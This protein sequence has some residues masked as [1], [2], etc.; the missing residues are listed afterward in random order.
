MIDLTNAKRHVKDNLSGQGKHAFITRD[1][2]LLREVCSRYGRDP[3]TTCI[4]VFYVNPL[5]E[6]QTLDDALWGDNKRKES[7]LRLNSKLIESTQIQNLLWK[8]GKSPRVFAVFEAKYEGERI[9]CQLTEF[10]DGEAT[11]NINDCYA[12]YANT[13]I[14]GKTYGFKAWKN[15]INCR[16]MIGGKFVDPQPFAFEDK[17]Y[18][19]YV[20]DVYSDKGKYGKVYYQDEPEIGLTGGPRKSLDRIKYMALG[21]INFKDKV[22]WDVGCATGYFC[23]YAAQRGAKRVIGL[24]MKQPLEAAF[25]VGNYLKCFNIDYVECNLNRGIPVDKIPKADIAFFLSL[26]LHVG[27]PEKLFEVDTVIFEDNGKESRA[28]DKLGEPW[29]RHYKNIEFVGRGE[30]HGMKSCYAIRK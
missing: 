28:L 30:D 26:N 15:I 13:N 12:I 1:K 10:I 24:D 19:E 17:P 16:D 4:K 21:R 5:K 9:A 3:T 7:D 23:R 22:V 20:K 29:T 14:M 25:H 27:I 2:S 8:E 6:G 18:L 11:K